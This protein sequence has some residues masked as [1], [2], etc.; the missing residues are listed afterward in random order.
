MLANSS[1]AFI[2]GWGF[3]S[4]LLR[5]SSFYLKGSFLIDLPNIKHLTLNNVVNY[6]SN[7]IP[8]NTTLIGWSLGGL[9]AILLAFKFPKK[10]KKLILFSS[11]PRFVQGNR[12]S[13]ISELEVN[14]FISLYKKNFYSLFKYFIYLVIY[15]SNSNSYKECLIKNSINLKKNSSLL[16]G[17]LKILFESDIRSEYERI[18]VPVF[19]ILG[20]RDIIVK[21]KP[22]DILALNPKAIIHVIPEAGH[23][24]F[25][26]HENH[27]YSRLFRF[28]NHA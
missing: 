9:I 25:L 8:N 23:L 22:S 5:K 27:F 4:S 14:K 21:S 26:T 16:F 6:V 12:W 28:I 1:I 20:N 18:K 13:G 17:Y 3:K 24:A 19:H 7:L 2:S 10:V 11:S 15:P